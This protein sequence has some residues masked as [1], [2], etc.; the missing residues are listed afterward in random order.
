MGRTAPR[1]LERV[2]EQAEAL[3]IPVPRLQEIGAQLRDR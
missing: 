2:L 1:R 3:E